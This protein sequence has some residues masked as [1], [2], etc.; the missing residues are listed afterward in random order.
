MS[1]TTTQ[2]LT[3]REAAKHARCSVT[4]ISR[5][6]RSGELR[7]F[8]LRSRRSWRFSAEDVDRWIKKSAEPLPFTPQHGAQ[9][10]R[11]S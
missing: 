7:G 3:V 2:W 6:A 10:R 4:T 1:D 5:A 8:K 11:A 9:R